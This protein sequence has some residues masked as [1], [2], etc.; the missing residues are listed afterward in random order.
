MEDTDQHLSERAPDAVLSEQ[1]AQCHK[2]VTGCFEFCGHTDVSAPQQMEVFTVMSRLMRVS[3]AL[4]AALDKSPRE[5]IHRVIVERPAAGQ[6]PM[7]DVS[8]A[9]DWSQVRVYNTPVGQ[10]GST[11]YPIKGFVLSAALN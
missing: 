2:V 11:V 10:M 8:P 9:N 4:A 7:V 6:A 1:L 5:F 3:V